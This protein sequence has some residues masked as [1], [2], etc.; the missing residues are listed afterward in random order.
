MTLIRKFSTAFIVFV[1]CIFLAVAM[2]AFMAPDMV[3]DYLKVQ[4]I[5][6]SAYNSIRSIYGG[7]NLAIA[8]FLAYSAMSM[9]KTGL[10]L[11]TL[12]MGGFLLGR[13]YT[14]LE[15]GIHSSFVLNWTFLELV[16]FVASAL[17][18]RRL[19]RADRIQRL[20]DNVEDYS[21]VA[22]NQSESL[23]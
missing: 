19:V 6:E 18:L 1:A 10:G 17:L 7:L 14:F 22:T 20:I 23:K 4:A 16:L 8:V 13:L 5:D 21:Y 12:Y 2:A 3:M 15:Q 9:R 11:I